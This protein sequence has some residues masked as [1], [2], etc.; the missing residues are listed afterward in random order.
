MFAVI[1]STALK[2]SGGLGLILLAVQVQAAT[3]APA[4]PEAPATQ[5][6]APQ[7]KQWE[8]D[9]AVRQGMKNIL[10]ALLPEQ[11]NIEKKR[12][13]TP[14]YLRL[15]KT[16]DQNITEFLNVRKLPKEAEK[17]FN[18]V[19]MLDLTQSVELMRYSP[20]ADLQRVAAL[21][22]LQTLHRYG[23]YF[24]HPGWPLSTTPPR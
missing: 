21:G 15:A 16:I 7:V 4:K 23:E 17:S 24:Q 13:A 14:D 8:T 18:L 22:V 10:Q 11:E 5:S 2:I 3:P 9:A 19:V 20:K 6:A 1:R 12:L